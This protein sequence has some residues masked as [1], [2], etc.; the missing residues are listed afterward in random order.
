MTLTRRDVS[1]LVWMGYLWNAPNT[2]VG[3]IFG[4]GGSFRWDGENRVFVVLGGWMAAI[5]ARLGYAGMCVGDVVLCAFDLPTQSPKTYA[6]ELIHAEQGRLL[7]PLYLPV[8]V[9]GYIWGF[10][11]CPREAHDA[12]PMEI[13]ADVASGNAARNRYLQLRRNRSK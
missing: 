5:F 7:G 10:I 11:V 12:S 9:L 4:L 1:G 13:W 6:H 8:T 2:V 3:L